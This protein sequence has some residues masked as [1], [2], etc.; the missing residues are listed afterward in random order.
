MV[1]SDGITLLVEDNDQLALFYQLNL[2]VWVGAKVRRVNT[3]K[4]LEE[5]LQKNKNVALIVSRRQFSPY[6]KTYIDADNLRDIAQISIG[7]KALEGAVNIENGLNIQPLMQAAA[8]AL[9][10]TAQNMAKLKVPDHF[11][12]DL[13][14]FRAIKTPACDVYCSEGEEHKLVFAQDEPVEASKLEGLAK[15]GHESLYV[16]KNDR[17]RVVAN[18]TQEIVSNIKPDALNEDENLSAN[19]MGQKL[20]QYK[21]QKVGITPETAELAQKN[22][23]RMARSA[24]KFPKM[25]KLMDR[26]LRNKAG[27]LYK[28]SQI[29]MFVC[30]HLMEH[31]D[32]GSDEQKKTIGF[33]AFF[34]DIALSSD[35]QARIHSEEELKNSKLNDKEK[36]LVNRHAQ[37][38]AEL[39][40]KF[41]HAPMGADAIIRQHHGIAHGIGFSEHYGG[42]LSPMTIVFI[43]AEDFVDHIINCGQNLEIET[44]IKQMR[45]RYST[46]RFKKIIDI[47]ED[48]T[49]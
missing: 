9:G 14:C 17:L 32:W 44:K 3:I 10:V 20:L 35:E 8:K 33:V 6:V 11:P 42:N 15:A 29:L 25:S 16:L 4:E 45:E 38:A 21:L 48:I 13:N 2:K 34:H 37:I 47:L 41:P 24:K 27:Y 7:A 49:L 1:H 28:H 19:E 22:I 31:I 43:L 39:V 40:S 30:S 18:I 36:E 26:L 12:I 23:K 46:Q 5:F